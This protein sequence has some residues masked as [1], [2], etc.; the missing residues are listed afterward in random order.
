L[1]RIDPLKGF[2]G[3]SEGEVAARSYCDKFLGLLAFG[4]VLATTSAVFAQES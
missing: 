1:I 2:C 3:V 4:N